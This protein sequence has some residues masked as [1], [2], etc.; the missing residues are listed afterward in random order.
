VINNREEKNEVGEENEEYGKG[1]AD[2]NRADGEGLTDGIPV[3]TWASDLSG[4]GY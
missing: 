2:S 3:K 4:N 1:I